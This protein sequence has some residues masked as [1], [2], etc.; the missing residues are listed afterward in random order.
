MPLLWI[1]YPLLLWLLGG[2]QTRKQVFFVGWLFAFGQ[3]V[4]GLY[5]LSYSL[6]VDIAK[7]WWA[8]PFSIAGL[9][10]YLAFYTGFAALIWKAV[11]VRGYA[12]LLTFVVLFMVGEWLRGHLLTGFPWNLTAHGWIAWLP[13]LQSYSLIGAYGLGFL[14]LAAAVAPALFADPEYPARQAVK[15][16]LAGIALLIALGMWGAVRLSHDT[17]ATVK[18]VTVRLVQPNIAETDKWSPQLARQNFETLLTLSRRPAEGETPSIVVWPES[19][20]P[21]P[22]DINAAIPRAMTTVIPP[23]GLLLTGTIRRDR[24]AAGYRY[25]NSL[26]VLDASGDIIGHYD[27]AHLTPFGEYMPL[28]HFLP[29]DGLAVSSNDFSEGSAPVTLRFDQAPPFTPLICYEAAFPESIPPKARPQWLL[30]ITNDGWFGDSAGPRQHMAQA[31]AR[32]VEQGIPLLRAANTGISVVVDPYGKI[33]QSLPL[34]VA[35]IID[36]GLPVAINEQPL[37]ARYGDSAFIILLVVGIAYIV[38]NLHYR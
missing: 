33:I 27:K 3:F 6:F 8:L 26:Q 2:A 18:D 32:A 17:G 23:G 30:N 22:L 36:A 11:P 7:W 29:V 37:Y 12:R 25:Y 35:G 24:D 9:P 1:I 13:I 5:W 34:Q 31:R 28:R 10:F 20:V 38:K 14:T 16:C 21:W 19:A 15:I 4:C